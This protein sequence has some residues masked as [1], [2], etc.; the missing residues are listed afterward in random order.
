MKVK[1]KAL[2]HLSNGRILEFMRV[3]EEE[4][5]RDDLPY[6][7]M[8]GYPS[9]EVRNRHNEARA[10][11]FD[12]LKKL[13]IAYREREKIDP[14][15]LELYKTRARLEALELLNSKSILRSIKEQLEDLLHY[16]NTELADNE[17]DEIQSQINA[18]AVQINIGLIQLYLYNSK[19]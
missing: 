8:W 18:N 3:D 7:V 9:E 4:E 13:G 12:G 14:V 6:A 2:V 11:S 17:E 10:L 16:Y 19:E 5:D 15:S 1:T